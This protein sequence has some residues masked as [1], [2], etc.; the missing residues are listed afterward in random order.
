M[1]AEYAF[2]PHDNAVGALANAVPFQF[3]GVNAVVGGG[4]GTNKYYGY[5]PGFQVAQDAIDT[6]GFLAR[7]VVNIDA[8]TQTAYGT[9][10][11]YI[12][13]RGEN[14]SGL[15]TDNALIG[16][17]LSPGGA[18]I[19]VENAY[20]RFA[21][22]TAGRAAEVFSFMPS[23]NYG[24]FGWSSFPSGINQLAYTAV[25]GGGLSA[26]IAAEDRSGLTSSINPSGLFVGPGPFEINRTGGVVGAFQRT[27]STD[28]PLTGTSVFNPVTGK[29]TTTGTFAAAVSAVNGPASWPALVGNIRLDQAWGTAQIMGA[30]V[31]NSAVVSNATV[32]GKPGTATGLTYPAAGYDNP[33]LAGGGNDGGNVTKTGWSVGF[34]VKFNLPTLAPGDTFYFTAAYSDGDLDHL[35]TYS[36]SASLANIGREFTGLIRSDRNMWVVPATIGTNSFGQPV[37]TSVSTDSETGWSIAGIYTHYWAPTWRSN[38]L[39]SYLHLNTPSAV[40]NTDWTLG[41][42]SDATLW[43]AGTSL[44]WSPTKDFDIGL[45]FIYARLNQDLTGSNGDKPTSTYLAGNPAPDSTTGTLAQ[46]SIQTP[47]LPFKVSPNMFQTRLRLERTF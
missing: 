18:S 1:R 38:F 12:G 31:Q 39:G 10:Q 14:K 16:S 24:P 11:T 25:L 41:G 46:N 13:L 3:N 33:L 45:E 22:F 27:P 5:A 23:Y 40:K 17:F 7:G 47:A 26:T 42:L 8:R 2:I 29:W 15:Y 43:Q 34:G 9:V 6:S 21:G 32:F 44:V 30:V 36:T 37:V 35:Q 28:G 4:G 20:I 19:T